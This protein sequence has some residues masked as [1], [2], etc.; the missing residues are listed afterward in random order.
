MRFPENLLRVHTESER[1]R[2]ETIAAIEA[3][4]DLSFHAEAIERAA[5]LLY[6]FGHDGEIKN[7]DDRIVRVLGFRGF[8]D[9]MTSANLILGCY[10]QPAMMITRDLLEL[11][12]LIDDF[13]NDKTQIEKWRTLP[14]KEIDKLFKPVL[15]RE[16]LG[17]RDGFTGLKRAETYKLMSSVAGHPSPAGFQMFL[18]RTAT[19]IA[20]PSLSLSH[21]MRAGRSWRRSRFRS[22]DTFNNSST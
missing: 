9:I 12:F 7:A 14:P 16:R 2:G 10:Y 22:V 1:L 19:T 20:A 21:L 15:V 6:F 4:K 18:R 13:T 8:N 3:S 5:N 11:T 17:Q